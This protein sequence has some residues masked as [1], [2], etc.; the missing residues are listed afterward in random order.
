MTEVANPD[1]YGVLV[2]P[3]TLRVQRLLPGPID[4][5]WAYLTESDLRRR[6]FAAGEMKMEAGAPVEL[7]WRNDE[8]TDPPGQRPP[9]SSGEN[10]MQSR[11]IDVEPPYKLVIGWGAN[12]R[13]SFELTPQGDSVLLILTHYGVPN[14]AS[15]LNFAPGWHAHLNVL[16]AILANGQPEPFWDA[17]VRLKAEYSLLLPA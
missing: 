14:R 9:G 2:E 1:L 8:L 12:G 13:V 16:E 3:T 11:I 10:R 4:R 17:V 6:W 15:L 7:V 5:I